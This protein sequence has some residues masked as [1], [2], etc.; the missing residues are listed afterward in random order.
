LILLA[1]HVGGGGA[2]PKIDEQ[3]KF[4]RLSCQTYHRFLRWMI[5]S[6]ERMVSQ[7][8]L[9]VLDPFYVPFYKGDLRL[10]LFVSPERLY[11]ISPKY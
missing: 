1:G 10:G 6:P 11:K 3:A 4:Q 8:T 9:I 2:Q 5:Y 7:I